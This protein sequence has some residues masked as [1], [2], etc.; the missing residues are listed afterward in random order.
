MGFNLQDYLSNGINNLVRDIAK[1]SMHNPK[2]S[3]FMAQFA[4]ANK[5]STEKRKDSDLG[6]LRSTDD[7]NHYL[8][9]GTGATWIICTVLSAAD[10]G[11]LYAG[12]D[13]GDVAWSVVKCVLCGIYAAADLSPAADAPDSGQRT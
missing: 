7:R 2:A 9:T 12:C 8:Q 10:Q 1:A 11:Y 5:I 4:L 6:I 3:L 13:A